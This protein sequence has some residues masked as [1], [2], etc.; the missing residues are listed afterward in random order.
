MQVA[1]DSAIAPRGAELLQNVRG[2]KLRE[3]VSCYSTVR[4]AHIGKELGMPDLGEVV[5][6]ANTDCPPT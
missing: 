1:A 5:H 6:A 2:L 4:L 3:V